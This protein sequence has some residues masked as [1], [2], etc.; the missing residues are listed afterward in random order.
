[1]KYSSEQFIQ[2]VKTKHPEISYDFT[3]FEYKGSLIK[4]EIICKKHGSFW[5]NP[6]NLLSGQQCA[7]CQKEKSTLEKRK[8]EFFDKI[9]SIYQGTLDFSQFDYLNADTKGKVICS[10]HG[11][12]WIR[13]RHLILNHT[14]CK[15]CVIEEKKNLKIK[16]VELKKQNQKKR[17][18]H[19]LKSE[20]E[21]LEI[22][23]KIHN[24]KY[25]Y[26]DLDIINRK[27]IIKIICPVHG[28]FFQKVENHI[29]TIGCPN[30]GKI[31]NYSKSQ[32][33]ER[34]KNKEG[35]FYVIKCF[36]KNEEFYKIGITFKTVKQR[37]YK[38]PYNYEIILEI[39][40]N[41]LAYIWEL[42]K[43]NKSLGFENKYIPK[44]EFGGSKTECF[45]I[46]D[47]LKIDSWYSVK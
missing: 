32:W 9:K 23:N 6:N 27:S 2:V 26:I 1:M 22:F 13:P 34:G 28:I 40:S 19:N 7:S 5:M 42:E 47:F 21:W 10:K 45:S 33:V 44:I 12:L 18:P 8:Q 43:S 17:I 24:N 16:Q 4:S 15:K 35:I 25:K 29:R 39:K 11:D 38:L 36:N 41:N 14:K 37:Y 30:C 20:Q 3:K 46:I 31:N